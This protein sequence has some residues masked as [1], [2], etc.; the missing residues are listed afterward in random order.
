MERTP[1]YYPQTVFFLPSTTLG[2]LLTRIELWNKKKATHASPLAW[3]K[4]RCVAPDTLKY[5]LTNHITHNR[6][7]GF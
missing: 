3:G 1:K 7:G 4:E 5:S 6:R 2:S